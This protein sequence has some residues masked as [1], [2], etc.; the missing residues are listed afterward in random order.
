MTPDFMWGTLF[1]AS[2]VAM[3]FFLRYWQRSQDRLFFIFSL[4]F[5]A[6]AI[7]WLGLAVTDPRSESAHYMYAVRFVAF[8]L[9][10]V[11]IVDRNRRA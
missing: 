8:L 3:L 6:L 10:L 1:M 11:G 9:F 4:A 7:N 2:L 5:C